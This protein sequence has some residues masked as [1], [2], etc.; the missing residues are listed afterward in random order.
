MK[1]HELSTRKSPRKRRLGR[2]ISAGR[3][4]TAGRG[5]KGQ[6]SRAGSG[7]RPGF[8][9]GQTPLMTRLP[10]LR[11]FR[12]IRPA[13]EVI[14]TGQLDNLGTTVTNS[15]LAEQGLISSAYS[16]VKLIHKGT[17]TKKHTIKLQAASQASIAAVQKAGGN[18]EATPKQARPQKNR[19]K[20]DN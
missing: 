3:G 16:G 15:T 4:K 5:T 1:Y 13:L 12:S 17:V 8:E 10:K 11:G 20:A 2:G 7:R 14:Y 18:F 9:G 6:R 19:T